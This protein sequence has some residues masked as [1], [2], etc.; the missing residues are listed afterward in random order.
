MDS[1][2]FSADLTRELCPHS[3][4]DEFPGGGICNE[5]MS[6]MYRTES[7]EEQEVNPE[8]MPKDTD[9]DSDFEVNL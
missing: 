5:C 9:L 6:I 7:P 1:D 2:F 4:I 8:D 3:D